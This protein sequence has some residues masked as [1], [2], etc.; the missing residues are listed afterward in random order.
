MLFSFNHHFIGGEVESCQI[1][2]EARTLR[3]R[4]TVDF[5]ETQ[6]CQVLA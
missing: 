1:D 4:D 3:R 6:A 2:R 5:I